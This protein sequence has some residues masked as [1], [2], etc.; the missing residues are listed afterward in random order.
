MVPDLGSLM[1]A[2]TLRVG[3]SKSLASLCDFLTTDNTEHTETDRRTDGF[4]FRVFGVFGGSLI[5]GIKSPYVAAY[6]SPWHRNL[7]F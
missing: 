3:P 2:D 7:I 1:G 6:P 5:F 4:C